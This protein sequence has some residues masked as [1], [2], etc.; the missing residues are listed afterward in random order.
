MAVIEQAR[1]YNGEDKYI[2]SFTCSGNDI[3]P[4]RKGLVTVQVTGASCLVESTLDFYDKVI[5]DSAAWIPHPDGSIAVDTQD[6]ITNT[7]TGLKF[8]TAGAKV[9]V[10]SKEVV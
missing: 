7:I 4:C 8:K 2:A 6:S 5:D 1:M 9:I 10:I 3:V